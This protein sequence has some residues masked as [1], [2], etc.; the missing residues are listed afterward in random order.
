MEE[1]SPQLQKSE[2]EEW[3]DI[4][5]EPEKKVAKA[6]A[7]PE[8]GKV[9]AAGLDDLQYQILWD[10]PPASWAAI[11]PMSPMRRARSVLKTKH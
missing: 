11:C 5:G 2:E 4:F 3:M 7:V 9:D 6:A 1:D 8:P 10:L